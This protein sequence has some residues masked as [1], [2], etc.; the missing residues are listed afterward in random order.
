MLLSIAQATCLDFCVTLHIVHLI[1]WHLSAPT[2]MNWWFCV[3]LSKNNC[4]HHQTHQL[5]PTT[6]WCDPPPT[7]IWCD[8]TPTWLPQTNTNPSKHKLFEQFY[9]NEYDLDVNHQFCNNFF[10][11]SLLY[12]YNIKIFVSIQ[13]IQTAKICEDCKV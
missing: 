6:I 11:R 12:V 7:T 1:Y 5:P 3:F 9:T 10:I 8:P 13:D 2:I 4:S